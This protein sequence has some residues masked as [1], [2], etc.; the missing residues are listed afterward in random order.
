VD[1][2][3][4]MV[5]WAICD[6]PLAIQT[7]TKSDGGTWCT[8]SGLEPPLRKRANDTPRPPLASGQKDKCTMEQK[9]GIGCPSQ[10]RVK[11]SG[12]PQRIQTPDLHHRDVAYLG[13]R[14]PV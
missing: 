10:S 3:G 4:T 1:L 2:A 6:V 14:L 11:E 13:F 8:P 5:K 12:R 7:R 9:V